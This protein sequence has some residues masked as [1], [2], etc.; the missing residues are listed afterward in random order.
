MFLVRFECSLHFNVICLGVMALHCVHE[1]PIETIEDARSPGTD[2][3]EPPSGSWELNPNTL[4]V[5]P[6][7]LTAE[8]SLQ[9]QGLTDLRTTMQIGCFLLFY[10]NY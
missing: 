4:E 7:L 1:V 9:G 2:G 3:Y 6:M 8:L 10:F 5:H